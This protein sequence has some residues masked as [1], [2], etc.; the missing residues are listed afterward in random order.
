MQ[1]DSEIG[2]GLFVCY[3]E[4][5]FKKCEHWETANK[6]YYSQNYQLASWIKIQAGSSMSGSGVSKKGCVLSSSGT[7]GSTKVGCLLPKNFKH[8]E[9]QRLK[10]MLVNRHISKYNV[11]KLY[12]FMLQQHF[13]TVSKQILLSKLFLYNWP[14]ALIFYRIQGNWKDKQ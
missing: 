5:W 9:I 14:F 3:S 6:I 2:T 12:Y 7:K 13:E 4:K 11:L 1:K 10:Y 8:L